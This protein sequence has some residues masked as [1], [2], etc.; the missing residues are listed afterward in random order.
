M[1]FLKHHVSIVDAPLAAVK[2]LGEYSYNLFDNLYLRLTKWVL[3]HVKT[4]GKKIVLNCC[5]LHWI[6]TF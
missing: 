3:N 6:D 5:S 1:K 4:E 2:A